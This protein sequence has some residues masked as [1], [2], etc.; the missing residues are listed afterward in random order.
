MSASQEIMV[1]AVLCALA[2]ALIGSFLVVRQMSMLT[3]SISHTVLLGITLGFFLTRDL[4]S[5]V[6]WIFATAVGMFTLFLT[7]LLRKNP[8]IQGDSA[9]ALVFPC[10]FSV[11]VLLISKYGGNSHLDLDCVML[12]DLAFAPFQRLILWGYDLGAQGIYSSFA[13]VL[14]NIAFLALFFKELQLSSF[15]PTLGFC[16]GFSPVLLH[17]ALMTMVSFTAVGAFDTVGSVLVMAFMVIPANIARLLTHK[18]GLLLIYSGIIAVFSAVVGVSLAFYW[19][20]S[21]AGMIAVVL[22]LLFFLLWVGQIFLG[23]CK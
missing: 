6:L 23:K 3:D 15:D 17:Y 20:V 7:E 10:L 11:A 13:L 21:I 1:I 8:L 16:L 5:P 18:L 4:N 14:A 22:G 12:G 19:D 2:C 9:I